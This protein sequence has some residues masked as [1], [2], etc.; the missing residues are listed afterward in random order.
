MKKMKIFAT[1][2]VITMFLIVL[3]G[4]ENT[5]NTNT[6]NTTSTNNSA[7]NTTSNNKTSSGSS[8]SVDIESYDFLS[9]AK[10][11]VAAPKAGETVAIFHIKDYGDIKVKFFNNVAPKAVENFTTHAKNGYYNGTTFHRVINDFMIQGGD[12]TATGRGGQSI[13]SKAFADE[14]DLSLAPYRGALCMANSGTN[15]N[16]SQFFIE[17]AKADDVTYE[18]LKK[19]NYPENLLQAYKQYGGSMHLFYRHTV[20][21]QVIEGMDVVDKIAACKTDENDKPTQDVVI[22]SIEITTMQ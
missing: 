22:E 8:K 7:T 11:Q 21:G 5:N 9:A 18:Q 17:Q 10:E 1:L 2:A 3:T 14:F 6:T 12:P 4:C 13:W 19:A 20:F 15:T 16:G